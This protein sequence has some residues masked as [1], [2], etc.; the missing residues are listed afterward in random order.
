M[1]IKAQFPYFQHRS[2]CDLVYLDSA[3][4]SHKPQSVIDAICQFYSVDYATVHRS[5]YGQANNTTRAYENARIHVAEFIQAPSETDIVWTKGT[6]EGINLVAYSWGDHNIDPGDVILVTG[7]EHH[8][9]LVPWQQLAK[10]KN[11]ELKVIAMRDNGMPDLAD[12][13]ELLALNPKLV[14]IQHCSNVLGNALPVEKMVQMA[15]QQDAVVLVDGAQA[16]SHLPVSVS[17]LGCDFYLFSGHKMYG[18]TGIGV[19]YIDEARKSEFV[20]FHFGGEM[21]QTVSELDAR[22]RQI[23]SML[24]SGTPN[25]A[26]VIGLTAAID[27]MQTEAFQQAR[28][29]SKATWQYL[30]TQI[31]QVSGLQMYGDLENNIGIL[32]F[33]VIGESAADVSALLG[34]QG[35][36]VRTGFQCAMPLHHK[37]G[38][39][40]S[41]RVSLGVYNDKSDIDRFIT[42]LQKSI[43][44]LDI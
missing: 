7:S 3:A 5:S 25:I 19:L 29:Q 20:P 24:E 41:V 21:V 44:L 35:I 23:P 12:Y 18:P 36:A 39:G 28:T 10:R 16:I 8:A 42:A 40:G 34:Q 30:L 32:S 17:Q 27:F 31:K 38:S 13:A 4:T 26:G 22:F 15:K 1:S 6:T 43:S 11:A 14:A 9:N 37:L 2:N 33:N